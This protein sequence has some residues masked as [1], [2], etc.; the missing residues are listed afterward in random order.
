MMILREKRHADFAI[1]TATGAVPA[2]RMPGTGR[3]YFFEVA[4]ESFHQD[5]LRALTETELTIRL[6]AEPENPHDANAVAIQSLEGTTLGHM[7]REE[8]ARYQQLILQLAERGLVAV[9]QA[10]LTGGTAEKPFVGVVLDLDGPTIVASKLGLPYKRVTTVTIEKARDHS[11]GVPDDPV[12]R[13][14]YGS[15]LERTGLVDN[16]IDCYEANVRGGFG[17]SFPYDRLAVI[18]RR[19]SQ[20]V[21]EIRVLERGIEVFHALDESQRLDVEPKLAK[22]IQ[23]LSLARGQMSATKV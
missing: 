3:G 11:V 8:A 1:K 4:G 23:R 6:T 13:N 18:Y 2:I 7:P 5:A 19:R 20:F 10:R 15:E 16:A 17:G 22:Y 21:D 14:V 9:C 12:E